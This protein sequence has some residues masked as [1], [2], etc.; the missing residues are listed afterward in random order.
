MNIYIYIRASIHL[1]EF[2]HAY[3][4][5]YIYMSCRTARVTES[6]KPTVESKAWCARGRPSCV[7]YLLI[8]SLSQRQELC[9]SCFVYSALCLFML[10]VCVLCFVFCVLCFVFHV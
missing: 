7:L 2:I 4:N 1:Y 3:V 6:I 5:I 8:S 10:F 9:V